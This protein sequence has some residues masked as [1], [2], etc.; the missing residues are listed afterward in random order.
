MK[1]IINTYKKI[2]TWLFRDN[3]EL[4][5]HWWHRF[6]KVLFVLSIISLAIYSAITLVDSYERIVNRWNYVESLSKRLSDENHSGQIFSIKQLYKDDEVI[7]EKKM[8]GDDYYPNIA[9]KKYL[10]P[11][12]AMFLLEADYSTD[13]FCSDEL[14]KKVENI[15][16]INKIILFS[17]T[18]PTRRSL[19]A[20]MGAFTTYL[21]NNSFSIKCVM[22]NS[23]TVERDNGTETK[24][25]FL[26]PIN[27]YEYNIYRYNNGL[28]A[29]V[30]CFF[31]ALIGLLIYTLAVT[32]VYYKII[33][34]IVFGSKK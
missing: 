6:F 25:T 8:Y 30:L 29:F 18:D 13:N 24:L 10:F 32:L 12:E 11:T 19:S 22:I 20:D 33:L 17:P 9:N 2:S 1:T 5:K 15:A 23:Y 26:E 28:F 14:Y 27:T 34:Y 16:D 3:L 21:K 31:L 7:T 4:S